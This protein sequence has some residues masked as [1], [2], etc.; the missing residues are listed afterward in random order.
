MQSCQP[1]KHDSVNAIE[2]SAAT[3]PA[4]SRFALCRLLRLLGF[5]SR[6]P[7]SLGI[8]LQRFR[9]HWSISPNFTGVLNSSDTTQVKQEVQRRSMVCLCLQQGMGDWKS[10]R[11]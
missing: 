6:C 8:G 2:T 3:A 7:A 4:S 1:F 10:Q 9:I 5:L 11:V